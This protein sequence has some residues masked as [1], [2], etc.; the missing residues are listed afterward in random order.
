[1]QETGLAVLMRPIRPPA[2]SVLAEVP[3]LIGLVIVAPYFR[4]RYSPT[5][6]SEKSGASD[7]I[8][9]QLFD[10]GK[11]YSRKPPASGDSQ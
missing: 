3:V 7:G 1:M 2:W 5:T 8:F 11:D 6:L 9:G 10:E 4:R